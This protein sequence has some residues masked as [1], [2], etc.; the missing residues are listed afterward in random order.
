MLA[1]CSPLFKRPS[2]IGGY[3]PPPS[4]VKLKK[5][6]VYLR[7]WNSVFGISS[8][9]IQFSHL[10]PIRF[11]IELR[12]NND[13]FSISRRNGDPIRFKRVK[14]TIESACSIDAIFSQ[15]RF[16]PRYPLSTVDTY[17]AIYI[18][19]NILSSRKW[20]EA[21]AK[22]LN[23]QRGNEAK[24]VCVGSRRRY[25]FGSSTVAL[26]TESSKSIANLCILV[27]FVFRNVEEEE[28]G[29]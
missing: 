23:I 27:Q 10:G 7:N 17:G 3:P 4:Y 21:R 16:R 20:P 25:T 26:L 19:P 8:W 15:P 1:P 5:D 2:N 29:T 11:H 12:N 18:L 13:D 14:V 22:L 9:Q 24:F 28:E 6:D